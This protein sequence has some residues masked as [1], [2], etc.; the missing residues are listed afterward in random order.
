MSRKQS[1]FPTLVIT[2]TSSPIN[3]YPD[4]ILGVGVTQHPSG[5]HV[6]RSIG[7]RSCDVNITR[8]N[9]LTMGP[10]DSRNLTLGIPGR[11]QPHQ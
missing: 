6:P 4:V 2:W 1:L 3:L 11:N 9:L 5:P 10:W 7:V 8:E